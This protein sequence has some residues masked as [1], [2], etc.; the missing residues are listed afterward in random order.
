MEPR[1]SEG[2]E[3]MQGSLDFQ[4]NGVKTPCTEAKETKES[5][6]FKAR[7][8]FRADKA[9]RDLKVRIWPQN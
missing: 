8:D 4:E 5:L 1:D 3:E 9:L 6:G 2:K 7:K